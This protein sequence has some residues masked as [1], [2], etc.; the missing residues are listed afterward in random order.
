[1]AHI[2]ADVWRVELLIDE[3]GFTR[4][5]T[6]DFRNMDDD[7]VLE[8]GRHDHGDGDV[9][10][11]TGQAVSVKSPLGQKFAVSIHTEDK[12]ASYYGQVVLEVGQVMAIVG[13][14]NFDGAIRSERLKYFAQDEGVWVIT[15]P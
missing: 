11:I 8:D 3:D 5:G 12:S 7:G 13:G 14:F 4:D 10:V 1:M 15:K 6:M 2:L 9:E